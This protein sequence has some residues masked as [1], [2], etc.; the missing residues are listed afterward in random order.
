[1]GESEV[2]ES[3]RVRPVAEDHVNAVKDFVSR[4]VWALI[5]LQLFSV[6]G[7]RDDLRLPARARPKNQGATSVP[8]VSQLAATIR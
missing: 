7:R 8:L 5:Q 2:K 6:L 1:M 4:Q 3:E